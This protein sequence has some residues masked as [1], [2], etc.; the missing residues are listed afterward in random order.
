MLCAAPWI[1]GSS[2]HQLDGQEFR[3]HTVTYEH[4]AAVSPSAQVLQLRCGMVWCGVQ[5]GLQRMWLAWRGKGEGQGGLGGQTDCSKLDA[6]AADYTA[7][8][9]S[10]L[11]SRTHLFIA[12]VSGQRL[13]RRQRWQRR[14]RAVVVSC[15]ARQTECMRKLLVCLCISAS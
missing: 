6:A 7:R 5:R 4:D 12:W 15:V 1:D 8:Q 3:G 13:G 9:S 14:S 2:V 11:E 10:V